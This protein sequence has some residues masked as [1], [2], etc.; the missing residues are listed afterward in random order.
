MH[1]GPE[2]NINNKNI[3]NIS[4]SNF[5]SLLLNYDNSGNNN[6]IKMLNVYSIRMDSIVENI[7]NDS[8]EENEEDNDFL[9]IFRFDLRRKIN[10]N[11]IFWKII[12]LIFGVLGFVVMIIII[13]V[14]LLNL[15][16][17]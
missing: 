13:K 8:S 2:T 3:S 9:T 14:I 16:K 4:D 7:D 1:L 10:R 12:V 17:I 15:K 5:N 11:E 6:N